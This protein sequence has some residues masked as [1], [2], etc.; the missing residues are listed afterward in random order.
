MT[1]KIL[2]LLPAVVLWQTT[3]CPRLCPYEY[4]PKD[5]VQSYQVG[6]ELTKILLK[7]YA[8]SLS[9]SPRGSEPEHSAVHA[10]KASTITMSR[11]ISRTTTSKLAQTITIHEEIEPCPMT[12]VTVP[13]VRERVEVRIVRKTT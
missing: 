2:F 6:K 5:W 8:A 12:V 3:V 11:S 4:L 7:V 9:E 10:T 1:K 13:T